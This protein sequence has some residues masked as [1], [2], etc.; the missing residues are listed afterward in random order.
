MQVKKNEGGF[1][2]RL[3]KGFLELG[4]WRDCKRGR[5]EALFDETIIFLQ[6]QFVK[7]LL[8]LILVTAYTTSIAQKI[9]FVVLSGF[10]ATQTFYYSPGTSDKVLIALSKDGN[11]VE[12]GTEF[13]KE[14]Y[15]YYPG[16]LQQY[17]G[18]VDYYKS[19]DNEAFRGK[20]RYIGLTQVTYYG[21]YDEESLRGKVKSIGTVQFDYY[22]SYD[23]ASVKGNFKSIGN[24]SITWLPSYENDAIRGRLKTIGNTRFDWY[25]SFDDK[26]LSGKVKQIDQ[27]PFTYYTSF[28]NNNGQKGQLKSG[29]FQ[30]YINGINYYLRN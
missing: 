22:A 19:T 1:K 12:Y 27:Y 24:T 29:F 23:D 21:T 4:R 28:E 14:F 8:I 18:R 7:R 16:K 2:I 5:K 15:G 11:I 6:K 30:K 17:M 10:G 25:T 3:S 26:A 20:I 13:P 9:D